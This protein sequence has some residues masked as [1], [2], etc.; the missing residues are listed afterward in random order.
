T[1]TMSIYRLHSSGVWSS[2]KE[3]EINHELL[4]CIEIYDKFTD[5]IFHEEFMEHKQRISAR[6]LVNGP[7]KALKSP[8]IKRI[9]KI[10]K[11]IKEFMPPIIAWVFKLLI[12]PKIWSKII[13]K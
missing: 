8:K 12:P 10:V 2:K 1:E 3:D 4:E 9:K 5:N 13:G 7:N 6:I 11:E